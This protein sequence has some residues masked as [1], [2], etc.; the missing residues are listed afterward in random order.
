MLIENPM[1]NE[2][3]LLS[4]LLQYTNVIAIFIAIITVVISLV[5]LL[6]ENH[7]QAVLTSAIF[8]FQLGWSKSGHFR[9]TLE[10]LMKSCIYLVTFGATLLLGVIVAEYND[11]KIDFLFFKKI[12]A[13]IQILVLL[14]FFTIALYI[15][16]VIFQ[17][18]KAKKQLENYDEK[19]FKI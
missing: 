14:T 6:K 8:S 17:I 3:E 7:L 16:M 4:Y 10:W 5:A 9:I 11:M 12:V 13:T 19:S 15:P 18:S 2:K 1:Q